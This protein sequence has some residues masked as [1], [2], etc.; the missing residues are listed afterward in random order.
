MNNIL[1]NLGLCNRAGKIVSGTDMVC[2]YMA[3]GKVCYIF[4]ASD[5]SDNTRKKILNKAFY[6]NIEKLERYSSFK[7]SVLVSSSGSPPQ[8]ILSFL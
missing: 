5:A 4:L 2:D 8:I 6:S 3:S 7:F 1:N